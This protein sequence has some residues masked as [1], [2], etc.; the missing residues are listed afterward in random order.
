M[1]GSEVSAAGSSSSGSSAGHTP[2]AP[3]QS[4][5]AVGAA[6]ACDASRCCTHA[7]RTAALL[8]CAARAGGACS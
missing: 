3:P 5:E 7:A 2:S 4:D 8:R 6:C 1:E